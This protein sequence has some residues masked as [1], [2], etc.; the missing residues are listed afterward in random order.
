MDSIEL[1]I[2]ADLIPAVRAHAKAE[3]VTEAVIVDRAVR[4][5][6]A[7]LG[8]LEQVERMAAQAGVTRPRKRR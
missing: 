3:K 6:L 1:A 8:A 5:Y 2:S 7:R 4:E